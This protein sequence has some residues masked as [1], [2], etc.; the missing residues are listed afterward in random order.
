MR[1]G[2][3]WL[4]WGIW[5]GLWAKIKSCKIKY[6]RTFN[7]SLIV[8]NNRVATNLGDMRNQS[9]ETECWNFFRPGGN[10]GSINSLSRNF[11]PRGSKRALE[12]K[13]EKWDPIFCKNCF[14]KNKQI[15]MLLHISLILLL[16]CDVN[17]REKA[18]NSL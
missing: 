17:K 1:G 11:D 18:A 14:D 6:H 4:L 16:R 9:P 15:K 12:Q 5:W 2:W 13:D 10:N 3:I 7:I 8:R